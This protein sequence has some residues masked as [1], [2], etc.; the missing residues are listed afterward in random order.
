VTGTIGARR[1]RHC[2]KAL[3]LLPLV[4]TV[5]MVLPL[6]PER[7][8]AQITPCRSLLPLHEHLHVWSGF[9]SNWGTAAWSF[10]WTRYALANFNTEFTNEAA[11]S[12]Y[13]NN[14][15]ESLEVGMISGTL[16]PGFTSTKIYSYYTINDGQLAR[17][18]VNDTFLAGQSVTMYAYMNSAHRWNAVVGSYSLVHDLSYTISEPRLNLVQGE[19]SN[20]TQ[21]FVVDGKVYH[22]SVAGGGDS[23]AG[24]YLPANTSPAGFSPWGSINGTCTT[25]PDIYPLPVVTGSNTWVMGGGYPRN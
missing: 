11:W 8:W 15:N 3:L 24:Y 1:M 23:F 22:N 25:F 5:G 2:R 16:G 10:A 4:G 19:N 9:G 21:T 17:P 7:A 14:A 18:F 20:G 13:N 12:I 6:D